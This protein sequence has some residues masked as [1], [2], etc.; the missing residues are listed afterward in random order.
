MQD[1]YLTEYLYT[2]TVGY[3]DCAWTKA[4]ANGVLSF[5]FSAQSNEAASPSQDLSGIKTWASGTTYNFDN[6]IFFPSIIWT[7]KHFVTSILVPEAKGPQCY[8]KCVMQLVFYLWTAGKAN[9][10]V[11]SNVIF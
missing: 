3:V 8:I 1:F 4:W 10:T 11:W 6:L 9:S 7:G 2:A 5:S